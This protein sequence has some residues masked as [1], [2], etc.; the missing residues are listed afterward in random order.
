MF[1]GLVIFIKNSDPINI[2]I[3]NINF[4]P[5]EVTDVKYGRM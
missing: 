3:Q 2:N 1:Y 4:E 5:Q